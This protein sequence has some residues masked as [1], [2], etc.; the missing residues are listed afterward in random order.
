MGGCHEWNRKEKKK[1]LKLKGGS[2][3]GR[4]EKKD[5]RKKWLYTRK[6]HVKESEAFGRFS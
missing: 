4:G 3:K 1:S 5:K 2:P 6:E